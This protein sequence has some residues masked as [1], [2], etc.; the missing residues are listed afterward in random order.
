[1]DPLL[2]IAELSVHY[3]TVRA[4]DAVSL[5]VRPGEVVGVLGPNG[6]GKSSLLKAVAGQVKPSGGRIVYQ[7]RIL[8]RFSPETRARRGLVMV[9]EG[10]GIFRGLTVEENLVVGLHA[11]GRTPRSVVAERLDE[12]YACFPILGDRR[13]QQADLLSGGEAAMLA[14]TRALMS[15]PM[16]LMLDEPALGLAPMATEAL[17]TQ[18]K[19]LKESGQSL[20]IV[21]QRA[22]QLLELADRIMVMVRGRSVVD[23]PAADLT[24][25]ALRALYFGGDEGRDEADNVGSH[26]QVNP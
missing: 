21:E 8:R 19:V 5:A 12:A 4:V 7:G 18:I 3:G 16:I 20:V 1:M 24:P 25:E 10:R 17:F 14:V 9:P 15:H 13:R 6:A 2:D 22:K 26:H 23:A 11:V